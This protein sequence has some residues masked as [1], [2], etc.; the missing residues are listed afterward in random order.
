MSGTFLHGQESTGK[1]TGLCQ[2][3]FYTEKVKRVQGRG[4]VYVRDISTR[5][6]LREFKEGDLSMSGT[7]LY[8]QE[9][10]GKVTGLCQG[11]FYTE[12][13]VQGK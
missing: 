11:H 5:K 6:R 9:S 2:G 1:V 8:G 12:K 10:T 4:P 7:F 13:R 3:H